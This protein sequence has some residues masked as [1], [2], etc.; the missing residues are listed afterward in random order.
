MQKPE[1]M[2]RGHYARDVHPE[3]GQVQAHYRGRFFPPAL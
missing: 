2:H 1:E 3:M